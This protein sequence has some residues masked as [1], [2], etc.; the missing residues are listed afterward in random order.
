[1]HIESHLQYRPYK[2]SVC[3]Y[4]NRK[5]IFVSLHIKRSH[6]D[7]RA[8]VNYEPDLDLEHRCVSSW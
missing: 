3:G 6:K 4:D 1:M 2:C 7:G 8:Q 5:E